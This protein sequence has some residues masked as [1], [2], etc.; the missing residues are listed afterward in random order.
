MY[1]EYK[2]YLNKKVKELNQKVDNLNRKEEKDVI[3]AG[4]SEK[5]DVPTAERS[6]KRRKDE[7]LEACSEIHGATG[8]DQGPALDGMWCTLINGSSPD[9][10]SGYVSQSVKVRKKVLPT[11]VKKEVKKFEASTENLL[12]SIKVLYSGGLLS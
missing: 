9:R 11:V 8:H 6:A 3:K 10:V 2:G 7:T 4:N 1:E 12:R 5:F